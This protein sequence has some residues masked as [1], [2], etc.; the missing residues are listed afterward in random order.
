MVTF[1]SRITKSGNIKMSA[2]LR[3]I[4]ALVPND[5]VTVTID[6]D[7]PDTLRIPPEFLEEAGIPEDSVLE[8]YTEDGRVIVQEAD[9]D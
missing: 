6:C 5:R 8:V 1:N 2:Q 7:A 9:D 4:L 3:D